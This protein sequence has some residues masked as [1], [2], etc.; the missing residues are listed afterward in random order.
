[1]SKWGW[2][3]RIGGIAAAPFTGGWSV[4]AGFGAGTAIEHLQH[5]NDAPKPD[6]FN[7]D[8][9]FGSVLSNLTESSK[10]LQQKGQQLGAMGTE[11][12][13]PVINYLRQLTGSNPSAV[14][15]ATRPER[16]RVLDQYDT[17]RKTISEFGPR[18]GGTTSTLA[19]SQFRQGEDLAN[20]TSGAR[21]GAF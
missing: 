5:R 4:P 16:A 12:V 7:A 1:M 13:G 18:G 20:V 19:E 11:S 17:A 10:G 3:A 15:D 6:K 14:M 9:E 2:A 8:S 21:Q